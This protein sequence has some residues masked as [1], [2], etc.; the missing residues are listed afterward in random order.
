MT[1]YLLARASHLDMDLASID[2]ADLDGA[3]LLGV[4]VVRLEVI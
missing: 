3:R 2:V 1:S 4:D